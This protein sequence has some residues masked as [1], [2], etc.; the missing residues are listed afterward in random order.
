M[1]RQGQFVCYGVFFGAF[2]NIVYS[3]HKYVL[4]TLC[5]CDT[6]GQ[7]VAPL[8]ADAGPVMDQAFG[9]PADDIDPL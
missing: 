2:D 9:L 4:P 3:F 6:A 7:M 8:C 5:S 1:D